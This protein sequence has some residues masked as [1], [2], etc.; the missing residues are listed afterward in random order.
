[1]WIRGG[2]WCALWMRGACGG[3]FH[4]TNRP[5]IGGGTS[6]VCLIVECFRRASRGIGERGASGAAEGRRKRRLRPRETARWLDGSLTRQLDAGK[7]PRWGEGQEIKQS[8][9]RGHSG[10]I[11]VG[12]EGEVRRVRGYTSSFFAPISVRSRSAS[13]RA[14]NGFLNV[15]L[16]LERSKLITLPS[17]GRR[18]IRIVSAKSGF[19]R[20]F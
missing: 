9:L 5:P 10:R 17:S 6:Q 13:K 11:A 15:S 1:M 18:A 16:M 4:Q 19:F 2:G 3:W 12:G 8:A 14:S 7:P 20:R